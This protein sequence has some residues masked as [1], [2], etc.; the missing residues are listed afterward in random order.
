MAFQPFTD[1]SKQ[2]FN[3]GHT[4]GLP[5]N[6]MEEK[7]RRRETHILIKG[8]RNL[9]HQISIL[10]STCQGCQQYGGGGAW[11]RRGMGVEDVFL[12]LQERTVLKGK[13]YFPH[14]NPIIFNDQ[15][16]WSSWSRGST[17]ETDQQQTIKLC[18]WHPIS[19]SRYDF[20]H[21]I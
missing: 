17:S 12:L 1:F 18:A 13:C 6:C 11:G 7:S 20:A 10:G 2:T 21:P 3:L 4:G 16:L 15:P 9:P 14:E 8:I 19:S 5:L